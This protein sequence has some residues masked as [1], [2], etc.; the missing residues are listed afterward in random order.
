MKLIGVNE[1]AGLDEH[2]ADTCQWTLRWQT[3]ANNKL[4]GV[5][6]E[7]KA[8]NCQWTYGWQ[9]SVSEHRHDK[10]QSVN[11]KVVHFTILCL[12]ASSLGDQ[13]DYP[14]RVM[15]AILAVVNS[16]CSDSCFS[17]KLTFSY[18]QPN[19]F[20]HCLLVMSRDLY[21]ILSLTSSEMELVHTAGDCD[22]Q[23][24]SHLYCFI[25]LHCRSVN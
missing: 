22:F 14:S 12:M 20:M 23:Y 5:S 11:T 1:L 24:I 10:C 2:K 9:L 21:M 13:D 18:S 4:A 3:S 19:I 25:M 7:H 6:E 8:S 15:C 16:V 17:C